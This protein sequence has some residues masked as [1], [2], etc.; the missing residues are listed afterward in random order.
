[1]VSIIMPC[2]NSAVWLEKTLRTV[3]DQTCGDW[4]LVAVDDGS[5]DSTLR[6]LRRHAAADPRIKVIR[7]PNYGV[8]VAR[9]N[10]M[11]AAD[12]DM[13]MFLDSDDLMPLRSIEVLRGVLE[14]QY[15]DIAGGELREFDNDSSVRRYLK[16]PEKVSTTLMDGHDAAMWSLYQRKVQASMSGK[17]Y[18]RELF[19]GILFPEGEIYE[20]LSVFYRIA[21]R[22]QRYAAVKG[23][24]YL[25]R[26]RSDS[27]IHTFNAGRLKVLDV[28][29]RIQ[30]HVAG[31]PGLLAAAHD[32]RL[33]A[34]FN[35][36]GLLL[37]DTT[38]PE[39]RR[40]ASEMQCRAV[41]KAFRSQ[42]LTDP[43][44][45]LTNR[46]AAFLSILLPDPI[47]DRLLKFRY[48]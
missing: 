40:K 28:T 46:L 18:R 35:M 15:A 44:V 5:S 33:S 7:Q 45:R 34:A 22:A 4:Q 20:D 32:R 12:G 10:A 47:F 16:G 31:D 30:E 17:L 8:S 23:V 1:M 42:T 2:H 3:S 29:R 25:Y 19:E 39:R 36:L 38:L 43:H 27:Q 26:Q 6:I 48:R 13:L 21:L 37:N 9:N 24:T 41:I 11:A 14:S